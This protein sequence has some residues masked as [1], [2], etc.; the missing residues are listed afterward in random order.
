[1]AHPA[2][3]LILFMIPR[4]IF[5]VAF[6]TLMGG[7]SGPAGRRFAFIGASVQVVALAALVYAGLALLDER[8][9]AIGPL[10]RLSRRSPMALQIVR[11]WPYL[12]ESL[13][14]SAVGILVAGPAL[15]MWAEAGRLLPV[16]A[17]DALAAVGMLGLGLTIASIAPPGYELIL[18][19]V[20][21]FT[22]TV[23]GGAVVPLSRLGA[24][25]HLSRLLPGVN[26]L[27]AVRGGVDGGPVLVPAL[28]ECGVGAAWLSCAFLA[29]RVLAEQSRRGRRSR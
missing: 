8:E 20:A 4:V 21:N 22:L 11:S 10:I 23:L 15:G 12:A 2:A 19:N 25:G 28:L 26:A 14:F 18:L 13:L 7:L 1:M 29:D 3:T 5:Q 9:D 16:L 6:L 17:L 27:V 24:V